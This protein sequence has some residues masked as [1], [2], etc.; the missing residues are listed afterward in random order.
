M[1]LN[2]I[3]KKF[4]S[5]ALILVFI[6][7]TS[8]AIVPAL[9]Q[10]PASSEPQTVHTYCYL[11]AIPNPVG[12]NQQ[13]LLHVGITDYLNTA[14]D[15][16]EGMSVTIEK[17]DG[18]TDTLTDI[19]T[20]S[21]GG[22]GVVY[23]PTMTGTYRM[24]AHFPEQDYY[25]DG[26]SFFAGKSG[27]YT[28]ESS[29]SEVLELVVDDSSVEYYPAH[30][31]PNE[32]WDRPIDNQLREWGSISGSWVRSP[33]NMY[34]PYNDGPETAHILWA[35][36]LDIGGLA[37]GELGGR[38]YGIGDAY[39]GKWGGSFGAGAPIIL[40]GRL[41]YI[42]GGA[43]GDAPVV[44]HC[45]DLST[46]EELWSKVFGNNQTISFGQILYWD[47]YNYHGAYPYL[48]IQEGGAS[49]FGPPV[50][51]KLTAFD[52]LNGDWRFTIDN[53]PAGT[54]LYG[55]NNELYILSVDVANARM[56]LWDM[57]VLG[58][59]R[60]AS[61]YDEG[62]WG[63]SV[64][65]N[66]FDASEVPEAY[67][68]NVTIPTGLSGSVQAATVGDRVIGGTVSNTQVSL[69]GISLQEGDE[70]VL[71]FENTWNAPS[72]WASGNLSVSVSAISLEDNVLV[73]GG[74]QNRMYYGFDLESGEYLWELDE[75]E[76]YMN[77]FQSTSA[78]I[79][80]GKLFSTGAAG[81]LYC[82]DVSNGD[83][84]WTYEATDDYS[85]ILW[86]NN[87]WINTLF[88]TDGKIYCGHEEHSPIDP[89]PRGAPFFAVD[90]KTGE[91]VFRIDGAFRQTHWGAHAIIGDSIIATMNTYD[92]RIYGVGKGASELTAKINDDVISLGSSAQVTGTIMDVSS[93]TRST[94][95]TT[96][97][98][99]GVP[100]IAD[101]DMSEW[102]KYVYMQFER[103][104][105]AEGVTVILCAVDPNGN[106]MDIDRTTSDAYGNWALAFKPELEGTYK[107][108]ATF[109]G[110]GAYYGST[111]TTYLTVEPAPAVSTPIDNEPV[112]NGPVD[113][114]E[115]ATEVPFITT[116]VAVIAAVAVIAII[117]VAAYWI[118]KRK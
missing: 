13:V 85:E 32:Y 58:V 60:A 46:G 91:E 9:A 42:E 73:V 81:I 47:T 110:S 31:L 72:S 74:Q 23:T 18:S 36:E 97:F 96:R 63:N 33:D 45:V 61:S 59:S 116:E 12:V 35:K 54:T 11:G 28:Y 80:E 15:G 100:A 22:T 1:K 10:P 39:E 30:S 26:T 101:E 16:W 38:S 113:N 62:S 102:M 84:L 19:R 21:T 94:A 53:V 56:T 103:P 99:S 106:Y 29:D 118:L 3:N 87:W 4:F 78:A 52:A 107:I 25:W 86:A 8:F 20:D 66:V 24:T 5:I 48:Y 93:G 50:P 2:G 17:P 71:L 75:P 92:Q 69:W 83:L 90:I 88:I 112:D 68:V 51:G 108:I 40:A 89:R 67:T 95:L 57:S 82:Y 70:G 79:A 43:N 34:A 105:D 37:G 109:E 65:G 49:M 114:N 98:P 14:E 104:A 44:T 111:T 76:H 41:Y 117:G 7:S 27:T 6:L 64:H 55:P 115:P 77:F